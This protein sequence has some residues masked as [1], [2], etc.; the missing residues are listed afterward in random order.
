MAR[1]T[2]AITLDPGEPVLS[3]DC[4]TCGLPTYLVPYKQLTDSYVR[5]VATVRFCPT[6]HTMTEP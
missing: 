6:C 2:I 3:D 4:A 5:T 1:D